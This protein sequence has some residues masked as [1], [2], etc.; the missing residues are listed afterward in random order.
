MD[1]WIDTIKAAEKARVTSA[2]IVLW[3]K[4]LPGLAI[5]VGGRWRVYEDVLEDILTGNYDKKDHK[6]NEKN[7]KK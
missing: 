3:C 1:E 6:Q 4:S 2:T 5:K 7:K